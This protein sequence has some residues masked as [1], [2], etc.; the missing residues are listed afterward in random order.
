MTTE[1]KIKQLSR[2]IKSEQ[3]TDDEIVFIGKQLF[4]NTS[5]D[6]FYSDSFWYDL[7]YFELF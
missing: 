7:K 4:Y 3:F 5:K 2:L 1:Q 6:T